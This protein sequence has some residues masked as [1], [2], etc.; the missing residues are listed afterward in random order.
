MR[1]KSVRNSSLSQLNGRARAFVAACGYEHRSVAISRLVTGPEQRV[2]LGFTE[3]PAAIAR[4]ENEEEFTRCGFV[5]H[6]VG[7]NEPK[8]VQEIIAG[9]ASPMFASGN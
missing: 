5:V 9:V 1:L 7:G 3:W 2:A 8:K 6:G 4:E